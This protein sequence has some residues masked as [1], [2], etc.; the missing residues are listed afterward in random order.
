MDGSD[1]KMSPSMFYYRKQ[2]HD[3]KTTLLKS[4][5]TIMASYCSLQNH[6]DRTAR[7][8]ESILYIKTAQTWHG[9]L[10]EQQG[11]CI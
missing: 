4:E 2:C 7:Y 5:W 6:M 1:D 11:I 9:G 8:V 3:L 10:Y